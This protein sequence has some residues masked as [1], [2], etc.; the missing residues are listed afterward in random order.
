MKFSSKQWLGLL[1]LLVCLPSL[2][3][4]ELRYFSEFQRPDPFGRIVAA[5]L[6]GA[7]PGQVQKTDTSVVALEGARGGYVSF[8]LAALLPKAGA[9]S[10][11]CDFIGAE[12]NIQVDLFK[13]WFHRLKDDGTY[14]PDALIPAPNPYQGTLPDPE[15]RIQYQSAQAFWVD[16]Y[17]PPDAKPG[18]YHGRVVLQSNQKQSEVK[19]TLTVRDS[20]IPGK[21]AIVVDHNSYG[22]GW[23]AQLYPKMRESAGKD[24]YSSD[25]LFRLIHAYHRLFYEHRGTFHQLGYGH[26]GK[27]GPEFAPALTGE[28]NTKR[29]ADWNLFDRHYAPLLD[30][31]AF[32]QTRRGPCPIPF[33]Y[34]TINP[35]WP[36]SFLWWGEPGYQEEFTR[37]I[38]EMEKHFRD[39]G[40]ARTRFEMFFNFKKR[41]KG[42]P[43]DGDEARFSKDDAFFLEMDRLLKKAL[44][45]GSPVQFVFRNDA[46][47]RMEEQFR[48]L[49]G[50][51]NF[52]ICGKSILSFLPESVKIGKKR[53]DIIWS[54]SGPPSI[55][56][57]SSAILE[58]P[59]LAWIWGLDGYVHWQT[60][61]PGEDPWFQSDGE[62]ICLAYPGERFGLSEPIPSIRLK[63][64]RNLVQDLTLL[65]QIGKS[66]PAEWIRSEVTQRINGKPAAAWWTPRPALANLPPYEWTN[67]SI[68]EGV[69]PAV[70]KYRNW[71]PGYWGE[72]RRFLFQQME[73]G[74]R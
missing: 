13:A 34:L 32:T 21:D 73:G 27:V 60:V 6:Q 1:P 57:T 7:A 3:G 64:Q 69:D 47:W 23:M 72:V 68:A 44:P 65:E 2:L 31:S 48:T 20:L 38:G 36:A 18:R 49:A 39:K 67:N 25:S 22:T 5:D 56:E 24:F 33:V 59:L 26:G 4:Q 71:P 15:N 16:L 29:I 41:Y 35:E 70:Q 53:G 62:A 9:Y 30:G 10:L 50:I 51:V 14:I 11:G 46:S 37:V 40:W 66:H 42:F 61:T 74:A 17:I 63:I 19:I 28:G 8:Q 12:G 55:K 52:W 58:N 54:Y 43:W 45:K